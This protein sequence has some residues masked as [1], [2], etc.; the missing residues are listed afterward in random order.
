MKAIKRLMAILLV[1][2]W[3]IFTIIFFIPGII[4]LGINEFDK[5]NGKL[6]YKLRDWFLE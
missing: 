1:I 5:F 6:F 3:V 2:P 4:I